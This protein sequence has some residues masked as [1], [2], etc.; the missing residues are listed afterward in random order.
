MHVK[1]AMYRWAIYFERIIIAYITIDA[2]CFNPAPMSANSFSLWRIVS[3]VEF[4]LAS[5]RSAVLLA[6]LQT[7]SLNILFGWRT[8][9][10]RIGRYVSIIGTRILLKMSAL[11]GI[12]SWWVYDFSMCGFQ[13]VRHNIYDGH[14]CMSYYNQINWECGQAGMS[15]E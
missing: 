13:F 5:S 3:F 15:A 14:I 11:V 8:V 9:Q 2:H 4:K 1:C 6:R 10:L 7:N 12:Y